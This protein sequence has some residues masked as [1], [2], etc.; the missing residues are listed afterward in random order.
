MSIQAISYKQVIPNPL[1]LLASTLIFSFWARKNRIIQFS[2]Y[3][4]SLGPL[5]KKPHRSSNGPENNTV[6]AGSVSA[7]YEPKSYARI[8]TLES[9]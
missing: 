2:T 1:S 9:Y 6:N 3:L 5:W 4:K 8:H 7:G